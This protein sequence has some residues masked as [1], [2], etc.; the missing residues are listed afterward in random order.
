MLDLKV[1][2]RQ[3]YKEENLSCPLKC[4][5][6]DSQEHLLVCPKIQTSLLTTADTIEYEDLFSDDIFKQVRIASIMEERY[7]ERKKTG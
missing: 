1:N 6:D 7:L 2:F 3:M 4:P 5:E